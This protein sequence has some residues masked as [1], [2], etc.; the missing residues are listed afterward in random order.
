MQQ[1]FNY[2]SQIPQFVRVKNTVKW[3][4]PNRFNLLDAATAFF[5]AVCFL[6]LM[7][8][9]PIIYIDSGYYFL[10]Q[11]IFSLII[12]GGLLA[13]VLSVS[14]F[15]KVHPV[16]GGGYKVENNGADIVMSLL[17]ALG[18]LMAITPVTETFIGALFTEEE[19][20]SYYPV[21]EE[22]GAE[23]IY[24]LIDALIISTFL[25]A[26][27]E[28]LLMRGVVLR[29]LESAVGKY[30][31]VI[32]SGLA[33]C[34]LHRSPLQTV[35]Q[36][37]AGLVLG[38][39]Y[40]KTRNI[41]NCMLLHFFNNFMAIFITAFMYYSPNIT[42]ALIIVGALFLIAGLL[43]FILVKKKFRFDIDS[44]KL[45][46]MA[47]MNYNIKSELMNGRVYSI[48]EVG[49]KESAAVG[50]SEDLDGAKISSERW[51]K[52]LDLNREENRY[53]YD[54]KGKW[55]PINTK[56][57]QKLAIIFFVLGAALCMAEWVLQYI[58]IKM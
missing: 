28:E 13:I 34:I 41:F 11:I 26:I 30:P 15:R 2:Y 55:H 45:N 6:V 48:A 54:N 58:A 43:Y 8:F 49:E 12:Q 36:L 56:K 42:L 46:M 47:N 57:G 9:T 37:V 38:L 39:I 10:D 31:A 4:N 50:D 40:V 7:S 14:A 1:N 21:V 23:Y 33:F 24:A 32:I 29:G 18:I 3:Y 35:S 5:A 51:F 16:N 53:F 20:N 17:M 25:P 44:E 27:C 22:T 52:Q 19:L